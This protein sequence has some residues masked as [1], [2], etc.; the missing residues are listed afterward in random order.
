[1]AITTA[2]HKI[3][4]KL[5]VSIL[6]TYKYLV[7]LE[8]S[9]Y[10]SFLKS[11]L[12]EKQKKNGA[13]S[14]RVFATH[15][16][17]TQAAVSQ[18]LSGKKNFSN[19]R[20]LQIAEKLKLNERETE[21]F[22]LLVQLESSKNALV[23]EAVLKKLSVINP[24]RP[25]QELSIEFFRAISDWYH[26][27]IRNMTEI[28]GIEMSPKNVAKRLG[29]SP[30]EAETAIDRLC[31]L[32]LIEKDPVKLHRYHKT[33]DYVIAKSASPS[34]ALRS[35][36]RQMMDK[37]IQSLYTQTPQEKIVGSETFAVSEDCLEEA[38]QITEEYFQ[39]MLSLAKKSKK[40]TQVY[41]LGVQFVN[42]TK[43][44]KST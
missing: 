25:V 38:N 26:L 42:V 39:K 31:R 27:V 21:F 30:L 1:M 44:G 20:A 15:L 19:E 2:Y 9:N 29:I 10:R 34:E 8:H 14:M 13:Y 24:E 5:A 16:G 37:A 23:K 7:I 43:E 11:V 18:V 40:K 17:I 12:A 41:H 4:R 33:Q 22:C 28:D 6:A 35:F 3:N 32:E 36:H